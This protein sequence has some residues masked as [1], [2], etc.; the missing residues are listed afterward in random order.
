MIGAL[1]AKDPAWRPDAEA[2]ARALAACLTSPA[3]DVQSPHAATGAAHASLH[4]ANTATTPQGPQRSRSA[5]TMSGQSFPAALGHPSS[6]GVQWPS[7]NTQAAALQPQTPGR[8]LISRKLRGRSAAVAAVIAVVAIPVAFFALRGA[9]G[10]SPGAGSSAT[11]T[12]S[13]QHASA[14]AADTPS[15]AGKTAA[16][17]RSSAGPTKA[18]LIATLTDP[19]GPKAGLAAFGP[20]GTL[21]V[22]DRYN[23]DKTYLWDTDTKSVIATF[24]SPDGANVEALACTPDGALAVGT[25]FSATSTYGTPPPVVSP[26]PSPTLTGFP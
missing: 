4:Q 20:D 12:P 13:G 23:G 8:A 19:D 3:A 18:T 9:D 15:S 6:P 11:R 16:N 21:A 1:L 22:S 2:T 10:H 26:P 17:K 14:A 7:A 5:G 25:D 24:V